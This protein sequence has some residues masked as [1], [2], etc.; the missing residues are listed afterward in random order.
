MTENVTL[1]DRIRTVIGRRE[2]VVEVDP[3][4][5]SWVAATSVWTVNERVAVAVR[6]DGGLMVLVAKDDHAR[7]GAEPGADPLPMSPRGFGGWIHVDVRAL[8]SETALAEWV[9]RGIAFASTIPRLDD[10]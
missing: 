4:E 2:N 9:T 10:F 5:G 7:F 8:E 3:I 1:A 6:G